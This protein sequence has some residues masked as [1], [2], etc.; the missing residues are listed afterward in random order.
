MDEK[1]IRL[2]I[3]LGLLVLFAIIESIIPRKKRTLPR[4]KRWWTNLS[5][6]AIDTAL[7]RLIFPGAAA[8]FAILMTQNNLGLFNIVK[9]PITLEIILGVIIL[10]FS[11]WFQ[12]V[13]SH[14]FK[15][16]WR[17]HRVHHADPDLDV[18][19]GNRFHPLE[20]IFSMLYKYL[21]IFLLG[22]SAGTVIIFEVILNGLALFNHA[23]MNLPMLIDKVLRWIIV[24]PEMHR[25]HHS[26]IPNEHHSNFGFNL[27]IWDILFKTYTDKASLPQEVMQIWLSEFNDPNENSTLWGALLIPFSKK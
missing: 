23:N 21:W 7:L 14:K 1:V 25:I 8:G 3:S 24:T 20:I 17:L 19:S 26:V 6:V 12:H 15:I 2:S 13:L 27:S 10:D 5:M 16:L 4:L 11:I 22:P 9:L 18:T